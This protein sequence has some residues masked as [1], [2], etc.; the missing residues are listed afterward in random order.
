MHK[1]GSRY[2]K[3]I[4]RM[5]MANSIRKYSIPIALFHLIEKLARAQTHSIR[6]N[7]IVR[8]FLNVN[9]VVASNRMHFF[10]CNESSN[11]WTDDHPLLHTCHWK[12]IWMPN[13]WMAMHFYSV[14]TE[15]KKSIHISNEIIQFNQLTF[16][17]PSLKMVRKSV[18]VFN[19]RV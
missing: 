12:L 17:M 18:F 6:L 14:F 1:Y 9:N 13:D 7:S 15:E 2:M 10:F 8:A 16:T 19:S 11:H 3:S 4:H 5:Y